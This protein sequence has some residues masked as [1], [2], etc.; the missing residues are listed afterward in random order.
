MHGEA[1]LS[2]RRDGRTAVTGRART[3]D[4]A[5]RGTV[6]SRAPRPISV[7]PLRHQIG[8]ALRRAQLAVFT[9]I[10]AELAEFDLSP[11]Q[12]SVLA[13]L[14]ENPGARSSEVGQALGIQ[15]ANFVPLLDA[16]VR[17]GLVSRRP[18]QDD[19]RALA[20]H[21]TS[22]G[23]DLLAR[24]NRAQTRHEARLI[25]RIGKGGHAQ[26]LELLERLTA[27]SES[28]DADGH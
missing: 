17:R 20:L 16:L 11:A 26:L 23:H 19:R 27:G 14:N 9:D 1:A 18:A 3:A 6:R 15:K 28:L 13:V 12:F 24:A 22:K 8:Y 10:I 5:A 21:M 25:V 7:G 4:R 2:E